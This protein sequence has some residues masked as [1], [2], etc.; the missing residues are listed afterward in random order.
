MNNESNASRHTLVPTEI[1]REKHKH[2]LEVWSECLMNCETLE[3]VWPQLVK[4]MSLPSETGATWIEAGEAAE[5]D[6]ARQCEAI[7]PSHPATATPRTKR[8]F[9]DRAVAELNLDVSDPFT[10]LLANA[11]ALVD[12][13]D[14]LERDL[15]DARRELAQSNKVLSALDRFGDESLS[16]SIE[17]VEKLAAAERREQ[18]ARAQLEAWK[19]DYLGE[20]K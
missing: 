20:P 10:N 11:F 15:A 6:Y 19:R 17:L 9:Y 4:A 14:Q 7:S 12:Q 13:R 2:V 1:D 8:E 18:D 3:M 16:R 5:N